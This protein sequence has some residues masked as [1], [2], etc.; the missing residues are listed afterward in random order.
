MTTSHVPALRPVPAAA[1]SVTE[2]PA[3]PFTPIPRFDLYA[4]A[5]GVSST[6]DGHVLLICAPAGAG[7]SVLVA[8]W[9]ARH[10][11]GTSDVA[12]VTVTE[13]L[14]DPTTLWTVLHDRFEIA[15]PTCSNPP[16]AQAAALADTLAARTTPTVLVLD[17]AHLLTDPLALAGIEYFLQHAPPNVTTVLCARF[18]PPLRW[19]VLELHSRLTRWGPS[20][21]AFT[22]AQIDALCRDHGCELTGDE[23]ATLH[24]LTRG[25]AALVRIAATHLAARSDDRAAAL[26]VLA[27]PARAVADFLMSELIEALPP[28]LRRFL[29]YT[30]IPLSFTEQLADDLLGGGAGHCLHELDRIDFPIDS[31]VRDGEVWFSCHPLVRAHFLAEARRLGPDLCAQLHRRAARWLRSAGLPSTALPHQLAAADRDLLCEFLST[32]ALRMVLDGRGATLFDQ[33]ARSAPALLDDPFLWQVRVVDALVTGS[34]AAAVAC[35]DTAAARRAAKISFASPERLDALTLAATIDVAATTGADLPGFPDRVSPTGDPD[36]DAYTEIQIATAF[37]AGGTVARG[38]QL[39]HSALAL[40]EHAGRPRLVL[41]AL[42]RLAFAADA[43]DAATAMRERAARALAIA[44]EHG[45]LGTTDAVQATS[46]AAYGAYLQGET[47]EAAQIASVLTERADHDGSCGPA[48]GWRGHVV[49]RLLDLERAEEQSAAVDALRR[50][51]LVLLE[52]KTVPATTGSL[53]LPVVWA[54]LRVHDARTAQLLV[55]RARGIVGEL[56]EV[57]LADAALHA[58]ADRRKATC[59]V[60]EPLL[61]RAGDLR[62]VSAVTGWLLYSAAQHESRAPAKALTALENA[63]GSATPHRLLRP[64]LDVPAAMPLL[65]SYAGRL[66]R[67]ESFAAT[68]RRHPAARRRPAYPALTHT[69]MTVLKQLPSGRTAQQIAADLGVSVNTVKTHLRGIYGKLGTNS[70]VEALD[71]AR[72]G[73]LL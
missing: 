23:L 25:W 55:E 2:I 11:A 33:L 37:V 66:G 34:T 69:E 26:T 42:T 38:E 30:S 4:A 45:L 52:H 49:G 64:F 63:L 16:A 71:H 43:V 68:I 32:C 31:D 15:N 60:L 19:H 73:G 48:A 28:A 12:W 36:L 7:K 1:E 56:P 67:A 6:R 27:R 35:L 24:A 53:I 29:T 3:L 40:A 65:D 57:R 9:A 59:A 41:R 51:L 70:R 22:P 8:D 39:L 21:L 46:V 5:D 14:D 10:A 20:E 13:Q 58:A 47:P 44:E 61:E 18:A 72:R 17:D 54:L 50:S 62:P